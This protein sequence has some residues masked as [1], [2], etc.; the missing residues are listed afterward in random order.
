M[1]TQRLIVTVTVAMLAAGLTGCNAA[2]ET[3]KAAGDAGTALQNTAEA[4]KATAE[5][6]VTE[7]KQ[8]VDT[9]AASATAKAQEL[10][11]KA[12]ALVSD[13]KYQDALA[14]LK[15]TA[16]LKLTPEHQKLVDDLKATITT[17]LGSSGVGNLLN[18]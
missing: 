4:A 17:A 9:A 5:K 2:A 18:K 1:K 12:K 15:Q 14:A 8:Q 6:A 3:Q 11:D 13:K 10:I 7:V 16:N